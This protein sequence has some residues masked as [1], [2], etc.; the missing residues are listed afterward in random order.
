M[1][2]TCR[3]KVVPI[4]TFNLCLLDF[5]DVVCY[6]LFL[7]LSISQA[8]VAHAAPEAIYTLRRGRRNSSLSR[9]YGTKNYRRKLRIW[10]LDLM[11]TS[12]RNWSGWIMSKDLDSVT[13]FQMLH[14]EFVEMGMDE[15]DVQNLLDLSKMMVQFLACVPGLA[16][17]LN[18]E[19]WIH[20][21]G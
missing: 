11:R 14:D 8:A 5:E 17:E 18:A 13:E 10:L 21:W 1:K 6:Y 3:Y 9:I 12:R 2:R 16:V 19:R 15:E 7:R 20:P 4:L